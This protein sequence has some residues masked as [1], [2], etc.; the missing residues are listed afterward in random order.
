M[1]HTLVVAY[2][3]SCLAVIAVLSYVIHFVTVAA[4]DTYGYFFKASENFPDLLYLFTWASV[5]GLQVGL[6]LSIVMLPLA[7]FKS[8]IILLRV[9]D[10][11]KDETKQQEVAYVIFYP[12]A[13]AFALA[14]VAIATLV[15]SWGA[16][17]LITIEGLCTITAIVFSIA[18]GT[19]TILSIGASV[20]DL[21]SN[22]SIG[23]CCFTSF[24]RKLSSFTTSSCLNNFHIIFFKIFL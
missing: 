4:H 19:A 15:T 23:K 1:C 16:A 14:W 9:W 18:F 5:V 8:R 13:I 3:I 11:L 6:L 20:L 17:D 22:C 7:N 21:Y 12:V 24:T 10:H 2:N